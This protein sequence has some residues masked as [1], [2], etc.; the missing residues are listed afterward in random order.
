MD[1]HTNL[2]KI[3]KALELEFMTDE[4][5]DEIMLDIS[6]LILEGTMIRV[7]EQMKDNDKEE[8]LALEDRN[9]PQEEIA[10]FIKAHIPEADMLLEDTVNQLTNDILAVTSK[11]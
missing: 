2:D 6:S 4:E 9:A 7:M 1:P 11:T 10:A 5:Q 8:L 3:Y